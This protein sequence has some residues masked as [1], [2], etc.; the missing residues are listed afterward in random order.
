ME[1]LLILTG[2]T[3][4]GKTKLSLNIAREFN[5][6][7]ISS[8]SMQIYKKMNI[9]TDKINLENTN[10]KHYM[11]DIVEPD[12]EFTVANFKNQSKEIITE[13]N[14]RNKLPMVVGG[15][16]LYI[17]SLVYNLS[18]SN[19][20]PNKEY[21]DYLEGIIEDKGLYYLY[22]KLQEL[23]NDAAKKIDKNNKQRVIRALEIIKFS[24]KKETKF[25]REENNSYNLKMI[26]LNMDRALLYERINKRVDEMFNL[27]LVD[28]VK[29][30]LDNEYNESLTSMKAIGYK[31]II[32]YLNNEITL[33]ESKE[34]IKK[35]SRHYAKRQLTWFRRDNRIKWFDRLDENLEEKIY[36]YMGD[37]FERI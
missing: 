36:D 4:I 8:D 19:V 12:E 23:D 25:F 27:G 26:G 10:I 37:S 7:I 6:E 21:R 33:E 17:N 22:E 11:V 15:T 31:E 13:I 24:D 16:G 30:L 2:P 28:E 1:N 20:K 18:F 29:D 34:L 35:N 14:S 5:G 9:G 3:G 32:S